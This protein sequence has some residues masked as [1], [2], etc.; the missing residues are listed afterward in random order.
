L[1]LP[2]RLLFSRTHSKPYITAVVSVALVLWPWQDAE[3]MPA[4]EQAA[5]QTN[6]AAFAI[7][8]PSLLDF[9]YRRVLIWPGQKVRE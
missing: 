9:L 4:D 3:K 2:H 5:G 8:I 6:M 7:K 1:L